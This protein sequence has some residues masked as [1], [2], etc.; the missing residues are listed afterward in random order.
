MRQVSA[1]AWSSRTGRV[2]SMRATASSNAR[3]PVAQ[4]VTRAFAFA[5][6]FGIDQ[7]AV[8]AAQ[9]NPF[10][11]ESLPLQRQD[12]APDEAVAHLGIL[13]DEIGNAHDGVT[14]TR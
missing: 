8:P 13:V 11:L 9:R 12:F 2:S 7:L 1:S 10:D 5:P 4:D 14:C 6:V 3:C